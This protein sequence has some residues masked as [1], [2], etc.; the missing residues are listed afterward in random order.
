[1]ADITFSMSVGLSE[2]IFSARTPR[3]EQWMKAREVRR[4]VAEANAYREAARAA[5]LIVVAFA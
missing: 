4:P 2:V 1:M 3:G 5:G